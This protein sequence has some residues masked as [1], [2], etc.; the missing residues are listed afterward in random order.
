M[1]EKAQTYKER[2]RATHYPTVFLASIEDDDSSTDG[3]HGQ[4]PQENA[5]AHESSGLGDNAASNVAVP[6]NEKQI[7]G[8][9]RVAVSEKVAGPG[10][11]VKEHC[12]E[13]EAKS[14]SG[15]DKENKAPSS[16]DKA[17][18]T[19]NL[20]SSSVSE[21]SRKNKGNNSSK[22]NNKRSKR[23]GGEA[24]LENEET[25]T[26]FEI[27]KEARSSTPTSTVSS[28]TDDSFFNVL[29]GRVDTARLKADVDHR[30]HHLD[31]TTPLQ[32]G[33]VNA[34]SGK[35]SS[36]ICAPLHEFRTSNQGTK[37]RQQ[38]SP[39]KTERNIRRKSDDWKYSSD[40]R[41]LLMGES[42]AKIVRET[43]PPAVVMR[44]AYHHDKYKDEESGDDLSDLKEKEVNPE[45]RTQALKGM[46]RVMAPPRAYVRP[47]KHEQRAKDTYRLDDSD[48]LSDSSMSARDTVIS[49][50]LERSRRR[51]DQFW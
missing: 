35:L 8:Y 42:N 15:V 16:R 36:E 49:D 14:T 10:K 18:S 26:A 17:T 37:W 25:Q 41:A 28:D 29:K 13:T 38:Q 20:V 11:V 51:R 22:A 32:G 31:R 24:Q 48:L 44:K 40:N 21:I 47:S 23:S 6:G 27:E 43:K 45:L 30:R 2:A 12:S 50:V 39:E 9:P 34:P 4:S 7:S 5:R 33:T 3:D 46:S 1:R 19:T